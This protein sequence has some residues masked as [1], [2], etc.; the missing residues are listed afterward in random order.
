MIN[1]IPLERVSFLYPLPFS[2]YWQH[3]LWFGLENFNRIGLSELRHFI[4]WI[5]AVQHE[6]M[7][8]AM[9]PRFFTWHLGDLKTWPDDDDTGFGVINSK[10][11]LTQQSSFGWKTSLN[12]LQLLVPHIKSPLHSSLSS[13]S[14]SPSSQGFS[15]VQH[16][17]WSMFLPW[18]RICGWDDI[19]GLEGLLEHVEQ[20]ISSI[21]GSNLT[22]QSSFSWKTLLKDKFSK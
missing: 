20:A 21:V 14:P 16:F 10:F 8:L 19:K 11:C 17:P 4:G 2:L 1:P 6:G 5:N 13:Q 18:H 12:C 9:S 3:G 7:S 22:Q 15:F